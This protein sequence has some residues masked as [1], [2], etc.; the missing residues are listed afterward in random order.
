MRCL[1]SALVVVAA[2]A[3]APRPWAAATATIPLGRFEDETRATL[4]AAA[5]TTAGWEDRGD[6][7]VAMAQLGWS[8]IVRAGALELRC[9][10]GA[11]CAWL[12]KRLTECGAPL[13]VR[14]FAA[15]ALGERL[16]PTRGD[17]AALSADGAAWRG[18]V[19]AAEVQALRR[20]GYVVLAGAYSAAAAGAAGAAAPGGDR[21]GQGAAT[22]TDTVAWVADD[23]PGPLGDAVVALRA[24]P[25]VL[26]RHLG[27]A[28]DESA[29]FL[30]RGGPAAVAPATE[31]APLTASRRLQLAAFAAGDAGYRPHVDN[32]ASTRPPARRGT[33]A[34]S[35]RSSTS[36]RPGPP[37]TAAASRSG[38]AR[39]PTPP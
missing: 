15:R 38:P 6:G 23:A 39:L 35:R 13:P 22:R 8:C 27:P 28:A 18:V 17:A 21:T 1:A 16:G 24:L 37:P 30:T 31:S 26:N 9:G 36:T 33:G 11:E 10:G 32:G 34:T 3:L 5:L 12:A 29:R 20:D 25:A 4:R 14:R 19:G 2:A 7:G